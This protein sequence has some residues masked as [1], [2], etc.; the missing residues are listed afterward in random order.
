M[1]YLEGIQN[2][3]RKEVTDQTDGFGDIKPH[4]FKCGALCRVVFLILAENVD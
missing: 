4:R 1:S 2:R 3:Q